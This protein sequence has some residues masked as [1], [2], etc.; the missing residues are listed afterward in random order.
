MTRPLSALGQAALG[1]AE[2]GWPVFPLR[3]RSKAPI[4]S[5]GFH[6]ATVNTATVE[7]W[8]RANPAANVGAAC[9]EAV[10][11]LDVDGPEAEAEL[12]KLLPG[13]ESIDQYPQVSTGRAGGGRHVYFTGDLELRRRIGFRPHLDLLGRG[14]YVILPPSVHPSGAEYRWVHGG[15]PSVLPGVPEWLHQAV[16]P[17]PRP[18]TPAPLPDTAGHGYS[19]AALRGELENLLATG[20][21]SRNHQ[22]NRAAYALGQL[23]GAR[24]LDEIEV[25]MALSAAAE[26]IG[27]GQFEADRTIAS[28]LRAGK[29]SPRTRRA[30]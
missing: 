3:P 20:E 9:G 7:R 18:S 28:G 16:L 23:V 6:T 21:G 2:L 24:L 13:G 27:L 17:P 8:W 25:R 29:A 12:H 5:G 4:F 19:R 30:S 26:R 1:Y 14:G 11:V 10:I 22:L 15:P